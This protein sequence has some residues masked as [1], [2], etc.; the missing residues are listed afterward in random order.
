MSGTTKTVRALS[1]GLQVLKVL[2]Q[3]NGATAAEIVRQA[4]LPRTTVLR[5]LETLSAE[6]YV[7][8]DPI[9]DR[10][11]LTVL[12]R[13]LSFGFDDEAWISDIARPHLFQLAREVVWP[14]SLATLR[15][16]QM[17]MRENTDRQSPLALQRLP[18]GHQ[19][20]VLGS[21]GGRAY[22][23][24]SAAAEREALLPIL[25]KSGGKPGDAASKLAQDRA[26]IDQLCA[27]I[28]AQSYAA[29]HDALPKESSFAVPVLVEGVSVA[30]ITVRFITSA[31][32]MEDA[33]E[34]YLVRMRS[35][36]DLIGQRFA[37]TRHQTS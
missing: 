18:S 25:A 2:N 20:S 23:A 33:L 1:R 24:F 22:L 5:S 9:D 26:A 3:F 29:M 12:T 8:R 17:V 31:L 6:G 36:A 28:R 11:R 32:S 21:S 16:G 13:G 15:G 30:S 27:Q 37:E 10:Y 7:V 19:F 34:R 4:R 14:L 35:L